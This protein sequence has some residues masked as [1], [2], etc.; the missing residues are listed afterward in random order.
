[1]QFMH[2]TMGVVHGDLKPLNLLLQQGQVHAL[3]S[4]HPLLLLYQGQVP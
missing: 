3:P 2:S 4:Y 1:M